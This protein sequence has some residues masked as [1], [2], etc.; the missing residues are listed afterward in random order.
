MTGFFEIVERAEIRL[1][2]RGRVSTRALKREFSLADAELED[3]IEELVAVKRVAE[4]DGEVL[5]WIGKASKPAPQEHGER[6]QLTVMFSD[7]VGST[8]LADSIDPEALSEILR[9][10]RDICER[11]SER[12]GGYVAQY[13]GDGVVIYFGYPN[14]QEDAAIRAIRAGLDIQRML[15]AREGNDRIEARIGIHTGLVVVD[16][17]ASGD[18]LGSTT[19]IAAR[20]QVA[21][22]AGTV[23]VSDATLKLCRGGFTTKPLGAVAL[24]GIHEPVELHEVQALANIRGSLE[25]SSDRPMVGRER[26]LAILLDRFEDAKSG[27]GKVVVVSGEAGIGKSR[28]VQGLHDAIAEMP[29]LWLD[30]QCS[31]FTAGSAFQ[32]LIDMLGAGFAID[33]ASSPQA[34]RDVV[35]A[36]ISSIQGIEAGEVVPYVLALLG[37]PAAAEFPMLEMSADEQR[38]RTFAAFLQVNTAMAQLQPVVIVFE[39]LHWSDPSTLEFLDRLVDQAPAARLLLILTCRTEFR[40]SW[41][42]PH[43]AEIR[44]SRLSPEATREMIVNTAG[45]VLPEAVL[46]QLEQ[47]SDG[48]P[49]FAHELAANVVQSGS[50]VLTD[51]GFELRGRAHELAIPATLQDSLMARLDRLNTTKTVAQQ[52]ATIGREF[53]YELI[54]GVTD[55]DRRSLD[56]A[57]SQLVAAGVLYQRGAI[58][59]ATFTFRHALLQDT[60]YESQLYSTR[61][62]LH[63]RIVGVLQKRFPAMVAQRPE[64]V[65]RHCAAAGLQKE[66]VSHYQNAATLA[67]ARLSNQEAAEHYGSALE[68]LMTLDDDT[69]RQLWEIGIRIA[70]GNALMAVQS[71]NSPA[72]VENLERIE[73]LVDGLGEGPQQLPALLG[74]VQFDFARGASLNSYHRAKSIIKIA[75]Q[76]GAHYF[77]AI[78][79]F[80]LGAIDILTGSAADGRANIAKTIALAEQ[81]NFPPPA[82]PHDI[83]VTATAYTTYATVLVVCGAIEQAYAAHEASRARLLDCGNDTTHAL[84][85]ATAVHMGYLAQDPAFVE[86][87]SAEALSRSVGRGFHSAE[88]M[89]TLGRGWVRVL[90]GDIEGGVEDIDR[91]LEISKT[92]GSTAGL[93][94]QYIMS[95]DVYRMAK[96]RERAVELLD[97]VSDIL[98]VSGETA[99]L[100]RIAIT[101]ARIEFEL[102]EHPDWSR[103]DAWLTG[104]LDA[105]R[106]A[107]RLLDELVAATLQAEVACARGAELTDAE[108]AQIRTRLEEIY[109]RFSE[110]FNRSP[111]MAA[112]AAIHGLGDQP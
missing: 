67:V 1:S 83:D 106:A 70:R 34:A 79:Y 51:H 44:L 108:R 8:A 78:G 71:Y 75:E 37:L 13:Q 20:I 64:V 38:E 42:H 48:V 22:R 23:V 74:L 111:L 57:L 69:D 93:G 82:T 89:A 81:D 73:A 40:P 54:A 28:L 102:A 11:A 77:A 53:G 3:L 62:A 14:A 21:A 49:L 98:S 6:R 104:V 63:A 109:S 95:A 100:G 19:N 45:A 30:T 72:V 17:S 96:N 4:R 76:I 15:Q 103:I 59:D 110:G 92:T 46:D 58:P 36:G 105:S 16:P 112:K 66:A 65:A 60:A 32:P 41:E 87:V 91:A 27:R 25:V 80:V 24:R 43:V 101:R 55:F 10:Y 56:I 61:R 107:G 85:M 5:Q 29:H 2:E 35:V 99:Y 47:R 9:E 12:V 50:L 90:D 97:E 84:T 94:L 86:R 7:L 18:A 39:D 88:Q 33:D 31:P 26:E 68:A 52:A